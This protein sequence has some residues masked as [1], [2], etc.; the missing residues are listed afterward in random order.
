MGR[1]FKRQRWP[2]GKKG[3]RRI[4][5]LI[6]KANNWSIIVP[7]PDK[8][9]EG[10]QKV[11]PLGK[12][13]SALLAFVCDERAWWLSSLLHSKSGSSDLNYAAFHRV[14]SPPVSR[15]LSRNKARFCRETAPV[16]WFPCVVHQIILRSMGRS[17]HAFLSVHST[18][19]NVQ[20]L[21]FIPCFPWTV[22]F[23]DRRLM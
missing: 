6:R 4:H 16:L 21:S 5:S 9:K 20:L 18:P 13:G 15:V 14:G 11:Q 23:R 1:R 12:R 22:F 3:K 19:E 17:V 2:L 10:A 8:G 7:V